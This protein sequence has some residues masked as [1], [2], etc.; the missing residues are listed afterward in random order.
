MWYC[1]Q[2]F[3][4]LYLESN[5]LNICTSAFPLRTG[6]KNTSRVFI[7]P[8]EEKLLTSTASI[9]IEDCVGERSP[10]LWNTQRIRFSRYHPINA[11]TV[12]ETFSVEMPS[13]TDELSFG[14]PLFDF[15]E[16]KAIR[17]RSS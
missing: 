15:L 5:F 1:P 7:S 9:E 14:P 16:R 6:I 2:T 8:G 3:K 12:N 4:I 17:R 11:R 10:K 13:I